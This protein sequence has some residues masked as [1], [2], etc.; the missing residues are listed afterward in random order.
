MVVEFDQVLATGLGSKV[1][2]SV[3]CTPTLSVIPWLLRTL[4]DVG[5]IFEGHY[6]YGRRG[7]TVRK[8]AE[9]DTISAA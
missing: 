3:P 2:V 7:R 8:F 9:W 6:D 4:G 1:V 5:Q